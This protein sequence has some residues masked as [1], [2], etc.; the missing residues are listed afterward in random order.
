MCFSVDTK[1]PNSLLFILYRILIY[2]PFSLLLP[3]YI[4]NMLLLIPFQ[5]ISKPL[6][7]TKKI[8][9]SEEELVSKLKSRDTV[10]IQALYDM[11]SAA[12]LGV[13]SRIVQPS[14]AAEDLLQETF[15]KIWNAVE[16]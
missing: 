3:E 1:L 10:A 13:I 7:T 4:P 14:E 6:T 8:S 16:S 12:L 2:L 5:Y 11:Y 15:I 9:F